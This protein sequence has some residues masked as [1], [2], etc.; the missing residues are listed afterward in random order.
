MDGMEETR[1]AADSVAVDVIRG[2]G[3]LADWSEW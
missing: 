2:G 1:W 3:R